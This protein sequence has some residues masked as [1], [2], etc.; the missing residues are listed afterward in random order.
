MTR[1]PLAAVV[2]LL[3][4]LAGAPAPA[5]PDASSRSRELLTRAADLAYNLDH[6]AAIKLLREAVAQDPDN[7]ATHRA[8]ASSIWLNILF[9]RGAVTVDHYLGSFTR[10]NVAFGKPPA[11][12]DAEFRR[13]AARAVALA[14]RRVAAAPKDAQAHFDLGA[15]Y[16]LEATYMA[17]VDGKLLAGFNAARRAYDEQ[18][19][20][21][22]LDPQRKE[23]GLVVGTYRY[24]VST[25]S[26]PARFM[27]YIAGFG[28]GRE[29]G[30]RMVEDAA[31]GNAENR[32]DA[33]F[34][35]V[36]LYN[37]EKRYADAI[38]VLDVLKREYPRNRLVWLEEGATAVRAGR[39]AD[40]ETLLTAG[41]G[42]FE[43]DTRAKIPG[44]AGLWHYKRGTARVMLN[45]PDDARADLGVATRPE[46]AP[47][48]QGRAH[49]ELA[50][51]A[52]A[53]GDRPAARTESAQAITLC[54]QVDPICV[55]EAK[56]LAK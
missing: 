25:L 40:A 34:A 1:W 3:V 46:A 36:L 51:L 8:L 26:M 55:D 45:R 41:I 53:R 24:L 16:G 14:E 12:L 13:E 56:K 35:L 49:V 39:P 50:R 21:L 28:G 31:S 42:L 11:D 47:W 19:R 9:Q 4:I 18:E 30:I 43:K 54:G 7:P 17:S 48:V 10:A 52:L 5:A 2:G 38:R 29:R 15:A 44:E 33:Q 22:D 23:A 6:D 37:R 27:A 20:V 32:T